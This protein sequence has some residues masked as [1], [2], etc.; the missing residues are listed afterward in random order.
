MKKQLFHVFRNTPF[1]REIL[2][3]SVYFCNHVDA[4]LRVYI[5]EF[6]QFLMYFQNEIATIDL[7]GSYLRD[8]ETARQHAEQIIA[9]SGLKAGFVGPKGKTAS[10]LPD[11]PVDF[12]YM[13]CPRSISDLSSRISLGHIG[14]KVRAIINN[15]GFPVL[16]PTSVFKP[17]ESI[18]VFFGGSQNAVKALRLGLEL[19]D[20]TG[21][22][23][24][25]FTQTDQ[26]PKD[27]YEA[28]LEQHGLYRAVEEKNAEWLFYEKGP[29]KHNLYDV[30]HNSLV[31][32]GAYGHNVIKGMLFGSFMEEVQTVLPNNMMIVGPNV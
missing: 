23:L 5:P 11:L 13:T 8:P 30:P 21:F 28:V 4:S 19:A 3:Q 15:A 10:T 32:V 26:Q 7:D 25:L 18:T 16:V 24:M 2:L 31:V 29:L 20:K 1:G 22:P 27:H 12:G 14:P 17:W 6:S 9:E